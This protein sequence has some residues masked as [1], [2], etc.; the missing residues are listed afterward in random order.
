[1]TP[2]HVDWTDAALDML[3]DIWTQATNRAAVNAA[4]NQI[5]A[6]LAR[7]PSGYG[8][9]RSEGLYKLIEP[10]LVVFFAIDEAQKVVE[11][12]DVWYAP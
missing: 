9:L 3:A 6:L 7:D 2:Y 11:I 10:P 1:M 12:S 4:Q 8:Q 5:D